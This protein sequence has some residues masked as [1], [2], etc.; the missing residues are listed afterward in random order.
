MN[1]ATAQNVLQFWFAAKKAAFGPS[2]NTTKL[3]EILTEPRL[4]DWRSESIGAKQEALIIAYEH[5]MEVRAVEV[6]PDN[7]DQA[8]ITAF[9]REQRTY[10]KEDSPIDDRTDELVLNYSVVR[11]AGQWKIKNW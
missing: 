5:E 1:K 4:S 10:T 3:A 6:D 2:H 7:P 8:T 11:E 9:V